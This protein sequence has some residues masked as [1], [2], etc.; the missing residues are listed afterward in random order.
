MPSPSQHAYIDLAG[1]KYIQLADIPD[2]N[3]YGTV[4]PFSLPT[5]EERGDT[6]MIAGYRCRMAR[7]VYFS[8]TID[9]WYTTEAGVA[10]TP[11]RHTE[12]LMAWY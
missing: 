5:P 2:G 7:V 3:R 1:K 8:N 6:E 11:C 4:T 9:I 12:C 10:G